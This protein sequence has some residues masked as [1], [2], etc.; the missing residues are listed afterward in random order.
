MTF[1]VG[2]PLAFAA[3]FLSFLSPCVLPLVPVYLSY[4]SGSS[5]AE[6][7]TSGRWRVFSQAL[8]FVAGFSLVFIVVFGLPATLLGQGLQRYSIW[9]ARLG[10]MVLILFGLHTME[11]VRLPAL[12]V[13]R[14]LDVGRGLRPGHMRSALLGTTLAA[15]WTPCIG[16]LLGTVLTLAFS[17]P[18]RGVL[19]LSVYAAG[20]AL[21]FLLTAALATQAIA[22]LKRIQ[23]YMRVIKIA[24]GLLMAGVGV[25]LVSGRFS[26]LN[27]YFASITPEWLLL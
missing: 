21:P 8:A 4:I 25:L 2:F 5:L 11:I 3:G 19:L 23:R 10:G 1:S 24:S 14:R 7:A 17:E 20:L 9:I 16:P 26:V 13:T 15:S 6:G 12:N 22:W 27:A 18:A